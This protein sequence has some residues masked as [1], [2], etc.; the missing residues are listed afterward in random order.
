MVRTSAWED[1]YNHE[2]FS[3]GNYESEIFL[4]LSIESQKGNKYRTK[5]VLLARTLQ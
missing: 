4:F 1:K 3:K 2:Y 5:G